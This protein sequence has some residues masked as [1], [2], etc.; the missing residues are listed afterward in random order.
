MSYAERNDPPVADAVE[1]APVLLVPVRPAETRPIQAMALA[2]E[3][4]SLAE[5][6]R[7]VWHAFVG[8]WVV[9]LVTLWLAFGG[10]RYS[11][12]MVAIATFLALAYFVLPPVLVR[13]NAAA[14]KCAAPREI[15]T[16]TGTISAAGAA[17]QILLIP[18]VL[19]LGMIAMAIFAL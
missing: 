17:V 5:V 9:F 2:P 18:V 6:P 10:T 19:T 4:T 1:T 8:T 11:A 12:F 7:A 16:Y 3:A 14:P 13:L 15:E